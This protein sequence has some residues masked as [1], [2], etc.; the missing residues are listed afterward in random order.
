MKKLILFLSLTVITVLMV[1]CEKSITDNIEE[2][3]NNSKE[4]LSFLKTSSYTADNEEQ[5]PFQILFVQMNNDTTVNF[6]MEYKTGKESQFHKFDF[7]WDG[8]YTDDPDGKKWMDI[9]I[10]HKTKEE[11]ATFLVSDS[12]YIHIHELLNLKEEDK[13]KVWLRF[14]NSTDDNNILTLKYK[15]EDDDTTGEGDD[16]NTPVD[17]SSISS[18]TIVFPPED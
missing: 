6:I 18:K 11:N 14:I 15:T 10:Y 2:T 12:A 3:I 1:N 8:K 7:V 13:D 5:D 4:R 9:T 17:S 16:D